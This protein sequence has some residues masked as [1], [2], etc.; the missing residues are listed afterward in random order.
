[1]RYF[2]LSSSLLLCACQSAPTLAPQRSLSPANP[3]INAQSLHSQGV[4][5]SDF[6]YSADQTELTV[7]IEQ[8][9]TEVTHY[10]LIRRPL[11][12]S[13]VSVE[14][15]VKKNGQVSSRHRTTASEAELV[16]KVAAN[17]GW[18]NVYRDLK[19]RYQLAGL[20]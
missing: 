1:M 15:T 7:I 9:N 2:L 20:L 16:I 6:S 11:A 14:T 4:T 19:A 8:D 17:N 13:A 12:N 10:Q 3:A 18:Q 5:K